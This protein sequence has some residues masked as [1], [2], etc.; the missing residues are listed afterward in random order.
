[1]M[2]LFDTDKDKAKSLKIL[3]DAKN[4]ANLKLNYQ[5][6]DTYSKEI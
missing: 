6:L 2:N 3:F 1:M 5:T 4:F